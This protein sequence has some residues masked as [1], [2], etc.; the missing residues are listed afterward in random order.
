MDLWTYGL[1]DLW[2]YGLMDLWTYAETLL[3][4]TVTQY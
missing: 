3:S 1:M 4:N 2:T